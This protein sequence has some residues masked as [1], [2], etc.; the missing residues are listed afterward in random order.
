[1]ELGTDLPYKFSNLLFT[2]TVLIG[3]ECRHL[4]GTVCQDVLSHQ[5]LDASCWL[6]VGRKEGGGDQRRRGREGERG[7]R[8]GE[9]REG[10]ER[11]GEG[12]GINREGE[13]KGL[14]YWF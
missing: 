10:R 5:V 7:R 13:G 3:K 4:L 9:G 8:K 11:E 2:E 1:M 6:P 12:K 14:T